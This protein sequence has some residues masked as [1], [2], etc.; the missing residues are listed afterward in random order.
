MTLWDDLGIAIGGAVAILGWTPSGAAIMRTFTK[1]QRDRLAVEEAFNR[2]KIELETMDA[3]HALQAHPRDLARADE[4]KEILHRQQVVQETAKLEAL[5]HNR[6]LMHQAFEAKTQVGDFAPL[7]PPD[8]FSLPSNGGG[9]VGQENFPTSGAY[10]APEQSSY[11]EYLRGQQR[12]ARA[13]RAA[14]KQGS[15]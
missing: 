3:T 14:G 1:R 7:P 10:Y 15:E 11:F 2:A 12:D 13:G 5:E 9:R 8:T 6:D 4:L